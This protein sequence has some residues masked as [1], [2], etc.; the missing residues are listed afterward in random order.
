LNNTGGGSVVVQTDYQPI[1]VNDLRVTL[2]DQTFAVQATDLYR[3]Q[4][5][6]RIP[7][8]S[9]TGMTFGDET[10]FFGNLNTKIKSTTYKSI[11]NMTVLPNRYIKSN[12]PTFNENIH[13]VAFTEVDVY[14]DEGNV[15]AVGKFS[16]PLQRKLNS[17]VQIINAVID[18]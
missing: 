6:I 17:D 15:V 14:D 5:F 1:Q 4:D 11:M 18:F 12:N 2:N 3:L 9:S 10:F 7:T 8:L 13:K 16:Q